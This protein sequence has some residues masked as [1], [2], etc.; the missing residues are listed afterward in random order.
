VVF[1]NEIFGGAIPR[2]YVPAV[3]KGVR[4]SAARGF[5]AGYPVVDLKV[6]VFD[7]SYHDVDSSEMSFKMAAR[8]AFRKCME[9]ARPVLLEPVMRVEIEAPDDF[10]GALLGD[11]NGRRGRVQGMESGGSGTTVRAEVPLAEMLSYGTTLTSITQGRGSFRMEMGHYE[12]VPALLA[13]KIL[14]NAKR[15]LHEEA[16]E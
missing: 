10:A 8:L 6:T 11:L 15:P 13:Q 14:A 2:Q 7:G 12:V 5:L 4:E 16:E 3:E 1:G 9:Q